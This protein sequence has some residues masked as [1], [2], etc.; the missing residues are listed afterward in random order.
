MKRSTPIQQSMKEEG[1]NFKDSPFTSLK[2]SSIGRK[3]KK[4]KSSHQK[5]LLPFLKGQHVKFV[6]NK[7]KYSHTLMY[8]SI[9]PKLSADHHLHQQM[10]GKI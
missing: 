1:F 10:C 8:L 2:T 7:H 6:V 5:A 4:K 9:S 3:K